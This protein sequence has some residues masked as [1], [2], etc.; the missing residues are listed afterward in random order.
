MP[1]S[2]PLADGGSF[3]ERERLFQE[4]MKWKQA[5]DRR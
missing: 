3:E 1:G 2:S 5:R 4:F